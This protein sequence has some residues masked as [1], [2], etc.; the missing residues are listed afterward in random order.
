MQ[1]EIVGRQLELDALRRSFAAAQR[2]PSLILLT[3]EP[4]IGKTRLA[5]TFAAFAEAQGARIAW[6][7][8]WDFGGAPAFWPWLQLL[9]NLL[10]EDEA[11]ARLAPAADPAGEPERARFALFDSITQ[12]VK[13]SATQPLVLLIDDIHVA[14]V[15]SLVLL[16]FLLRDPRPAPILFVGT[17]R[18][19]PTEATGEV[20][21]LIGELGRLGETLP[22]S[23]L[24]AD[25]VQ[26]WLSLARGG[27]PASGGA[28][29]ADEA[30]ELV[31][32]SGGNPFFIGELLQ[33]RSSGPC[34]LPS[35]IREALRQQIRRLSPGAQ[36]VLSATS[37][38]GRGATAYLLERVAQ[39]ALPEILEALR[40]CLQS[41]LLVETRERVGH[42]AFAHALAREVTYADL[43]VATQLE[44][45]HRAGEALENLYGDDR[46]AHAAELA[47]HLLAAG[48]T[49]ATQR[50][51]G[52][53]LTAAQRAM[54]MAAYEEAAS[55]V[56]RALDIVARDGRPGQEP[57]RCLLLLLAAEAWIASG[58]MAKATA[59]FQR[60]MAVATE[61]R[62]A[63][64]WR[65]PI[66]AALDA[67][68][69]GY[70]ERL[71]SFAPT[72][73]D[74]FAVAAL[75]MARSNPLPFTE[76]AHVKALETALGRLSGDTPLR[77]MVLA[78]L[79]AEL[80]ADPTSLE[81]REA[82][83]T[84]AVTVAR[85]VQ[86]PPRILVAVLNARL[87]A[88]RGPESMEERAA[89]AEEMLSLADQAGD[90]VARLE[91]LRWRMGAAFELGNFA[92]GD[93]DLQEYTRIAEQVKQWGPL[94]TAAM[95]G[96]MR[97]Y[98]AGDYARGRAL[99]ERGRELA[100][101]SNL[102]VSLMLAEAREVFAHVD[103]GRTEEIIV[104]VDGMRA[105]LREKRGAG[106]FGARLEAVL[107]WAL[108]HAGR[109]EEAR[110]T[111]VRLAPQALEQA[112]PDHTR[113]VELALLGEV[114]AVAGPAE[115][116][117]RFHQLLLPWRD[118]VVMADTVACFGP[119]SRYLAV[120]AE[121]MGQLDLACEHAEHAVEMARRIGEGSIAARAL[122]EAALVLLKRGRAA[123]V[124]TARAHA[125]A[126]RAM[127]ARMGMA[128]LLARLEGLDLDKVAPTP[129]AAA[130][131]AVAVPA[132]RAAPVVVE[133]AGLALVFRR[134]GK[135]W[136]CGRPARTVAV[137]HVRGMGYLHRLMEAAGKEVH[138]LE[139]VSENG[140]SVPQAARGDG[141]G[142]VLDA[143]AKAE[144]REELAS[145][146]EEL[147]EAEGFQD[148]GRAEHI[149]EEI[150]LFT[151]QLAAAVG[152]GGRD[153]K[154]SS[155]TEKARMSA[156]VA[157]KR[158]IKA[159]AAADSVVGQHLEASIH[160]GTFC[161]YAP[162]PS[163]S[164]QITLY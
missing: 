81:R 41:G 11:E 131:P 44:L 110:A 56:E 1:V 18:Q 7:R 59:A 15:P 36:A 143:R 139:L 22:L 145:L 135:D 128:P 33:S 147:E 78:Q 30:R 54:R 152:L 121:A 88:V 102:P 23:G 43:P 162:D 96:G 138:V 51:L 119:V 127:A 3:G 45:H 141:A 42:Y 94:D 40:E 132:A 114:A 48:D 4:G 68:H 109:V 5:E 120:L 67:V 125:S 26:S 85:R 25:E 70:R 14:D 53:L 10:G 153:R 75:H 111:L 140:T 66:C 104:A 146:Q 17:A 76:E 28:D 100:R 82:L 154:A 106:S 151:S 9:R 103:Q 47:R 2:R 58:A 74:C 8:C 31:Q 12:A 35:T 112:R 86:A 55:H 64:A 134:E 69:R 60:V 91:G 46:E 144:Y 38:V 89:A 61:T 117:A 79:A 71:V 133:P 157:I 29:R 65:E 90:P 161:S 156:T 6:A 136:Q 124:E 148:E 150:E 77:A 83:T 21:E 159:V 163:L 52:Y 63:P 107:A 62:N 50:G 87:L 84:E 105:V 27:S 80:R 129:P 49:A 19:S 93:S 34:V 160:T 16:R 155:T 98:V 92:A 37:V 39:R 122:G 24:S 32:A 99:N 126:A 137:K 95:V 108:L 101:I 118:R 72:A 13:R 97:A 57:E 20:R 142:P 113:T 130:K 158:A 123:D 116:Q 115:L 73:D 164:V 149:R